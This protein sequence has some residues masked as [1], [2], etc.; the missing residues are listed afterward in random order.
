MYL[1]M[2]G[3]RSAQHSAAP[4]AST[5]EQAHPLTTG[6]LVVRFRLRRD[7]NVEQWEGKT[8][9]VKSDDS[10]RATSRPEL[11]AYGWVISILT[12]WLFTATR[13]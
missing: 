9:S 4:A 10:I 7:T 3:Y 12:I 13:F 2:R 11:V 8:M 1:E 5:R 6:R